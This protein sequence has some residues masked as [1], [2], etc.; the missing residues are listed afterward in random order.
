MGIWDKI[1]G[2]PNLK[3][4]KSLQPIIDKIN[5]L[6]EEYQKKT[7]EELKEKTFEFKKRL[8]SFEGE[9][10]KYSPEEEQ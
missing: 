10:K 4:I 1:F 9:E 6:E 3:I 5:S 8:G 2:D 7:L